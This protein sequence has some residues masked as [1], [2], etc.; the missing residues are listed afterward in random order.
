MPETR[1]ARLNDDAYSAIKTLK[2]ETRKLGGTYS[3]SDIVTVS[4]VIMGILLKVSSGVI[5]RMLDDA[6][7]LRLKKL[8]GEFE[9]S[10]PEV[11]I[12]RYSHEL[13]AKSGDQGKQIEDIISKL[14]DENDLEV[15]ARLL[16]KY[17]HLLG[18]DKVRD[19]S[20]EILTKMRE[21]ERS[22]ASNK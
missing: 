22:S 16:F 5:K 11:L 17:K 15:A 3:V 4:A 20:A 6:K 12:A 1:G 14:I 13:I 7:D 18:E 21:S 9:G 10:I 8:R 19:F 2:N